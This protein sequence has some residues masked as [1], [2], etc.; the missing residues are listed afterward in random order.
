MREREKKYIQGGGGSKKKKK[1]NPKQMN[2][3]E[4]II[5]INKENIY[6]LLKFTLCLSW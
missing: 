2:I 3:K 1:A 6:V 5:L 4:T